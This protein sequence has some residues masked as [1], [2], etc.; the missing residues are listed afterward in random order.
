[1]ENGLLDI[2]GR[3]SNMTDEEIFE[4]VLAAR[5]AQDEGPINSV[6]DD[7]EESWRSHCLKHSHPPL[8]N[9]KETWRHLGNVALGLRKRWPTRHVG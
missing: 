1:M 4:A 2:G 7:A 5:K 6:D 8:K 3:E 9:I